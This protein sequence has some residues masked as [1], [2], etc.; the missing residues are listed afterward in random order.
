METYKIVFTVFD[1]HRDFD[2]PSMPPH[3][4]DNALI[5]KQIFYWTFCNNIMECLQSLDRLAF[6]AL[7]IV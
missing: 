2:V 1:Q 3:P 5:F 7:P 4:L 6:R